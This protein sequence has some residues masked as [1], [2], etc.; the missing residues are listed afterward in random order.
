MSLT[1]TSFFAALIV[2]TVVMMVGAIALWPKVRGPRAVRWLVHAVMIGLCQLTAISVVATW[3]NNSYG[4]Y[5]SWDDLLGN[6]NTNAVAMPGPPV[7]RAKFSKSTKG[8]VLDTYFHG[9][10]S[11]LSGEVLVWTPPQYDEAAYAK[12]RFPVIML[13]HG[14]PGSPQSWLEHGGMPGAFEDLLKQNKVHPFILVMPV[15]NPGSVDTDC[16][17][18]PNRKVATW[19]AAD[20]PD[21]VSHK[22]RTLSGPRG[23]GLMGFS[24][25]GFCAAKLPLQFPKVFGAGAALDPDP[26]TGD[27]SVLPDPAVRRH[28]SPMYLVRHTK[29]RVR[30]FLA[31]SRQDRLSPTSYI[32]TFQATAGATPV[33]VRTLVLPS[34]GH[35]YNTWSAEYPAAFGWLS[36]WL[37]APR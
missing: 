18:L 13:L 19:M 1:S 34:G 9:R 31:T 26:L 8:G 4:L 23:W 25:G 12:K 17:D 5:A 37:S 14:V 16:S 20:V 3:I 35:N 2:A 32:E 30:L 11:A 24:T 36:Q 6:P 21:L 15:V 27:E 28:N 33:E 10:R 7:H 22:F 29:A